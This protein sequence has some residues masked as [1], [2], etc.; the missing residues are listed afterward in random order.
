MVKWLSIFLFV[1]SIGISSFAQ[2]NALII[3]GTSPDLYLIHKVVPKENF[4]SYYNFED[5]DALINGSLIMWFE[6]CII[7]KMSYKY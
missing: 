3:E 5:E 6:T 4:Y 2:K 1:F 7:F